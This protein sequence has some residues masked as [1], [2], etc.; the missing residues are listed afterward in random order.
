MFGAI[1]RW[2]A[3]GARPQAPPA[4]PPP[5]PEQLLAPVSAALQSGDEAEALRLLEALVWQHPQLGEAHRLLGQLHH[6]RGDKVEARDSYTLAIHCA[7]AS[8]QAHY[9]L[10]LLEM[11]ERRFETA[12]REL[13]RAAALSPD[14]AAVWNSLGAAH[15]ESGAYAL[16]V[17]HFRR[18]IALDPAFADAHSNL[19][20]VLFRELEQYEEGAAALERAIV[21]GAN[22]LEVR[23]NWAIVLQQ[24]GDDEAAL[25][26]Y[27]DLLDAD[28]TLAQVRLNRAL[29]RLA[30]G[31][32]GGGWADYEARAAIPQYAAALGAAPEWDGSDLTGRSIAL[33][34]EQGLGDE[35]MFASCVPD[36]L[37]KAASCVLVCHPKLVPIFSRSFP[38]A[39][40]RSSTAPASDLERNASFSARIGSLPRFLRRER[41]DFPARGGYLA[42]DPMRVAHWRMRL[43]E[44][45]GKYKVGISWRGGTATTS[46]RMRSIPLEQWEPLLQ[47]AG[48]DFVSLQY[49]DAA[50]EIE[51][52]ERA[53]GV[54]IHRWQD[55]LDVY[56]E[57]AALIAALDLVLS[58]Q[59]AVVHLAGALDA[60]AWALIPEVPE[61]R[62]GERGE[63]MP[64]Y[65]SVTLWR[66]ERGQEWSSVL[67]RVARRLGER[68]ERGDA[69]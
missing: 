24:R 68:L 13:E 21:L 62:Y 66:R 50:Q 35:I 8:W 10:A 5:D 23:L 20:Y 64:W 22:R 14:S 18:A 45:P 56:D 46:R 28:P 33:Y 2:F 7:P 49:T 29:L 41:R 39:S 37:A 25:A 31:D 60:P 69:S 16:S 42:P 15:A 53:A 30:R 38:R 44:L 67:E 61:W 47:I 48:V 17:E 43:A 3:R 59:T 9:G 58:V 57:T 54:R 40:V 1:R 6:R 36:V 26:V 34:P 55:A 51:T 27:D 19:G 63:S 11:E 52:V 4:A 12:I 65:R 32:F